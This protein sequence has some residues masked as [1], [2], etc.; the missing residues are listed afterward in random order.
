[1]P[2]QRSPLERTTTTPYLTPKTSNILTDSIFGVK[3]KNVDNAVKR[4][5]LIMDNSPEAQNLNMAE[6]MLVMSE[7]LIKAVESMEEMK[8]MMERILKENK[9]VKE[10]LEMIKIGLKNNGQR[11]E[12]II[13][14]TE[15]QNKEEQSGGEKSKKKGYADVLK[16]MKPALLV[17]G[18]KDGETAKEIMQE[19]KKKVSPKTAKIRGT[20]ET[21]RGNIIIE[22][23]NQEAVK[24][25]KEKVEKR[26]GPKVNVEIVEKRRPKVKV[27]G[28]EGEFTKE[29]IEEYLMEM[30]GDIFTT[31]EQFDIVHIF[32]TSRIKGFKMELEPEVY[33]LVM[34]RKSLMVG[35]FPCRVQECLDV[36][37]CYKCQGFGHK[38]MKCTNET[39]CAKCGGKH[40]YKE[41]KSEIEQCVNCMNVNK[42]ANMNLDVNHIAWSNTCS[43]LRRKETLERR[44]VE[45]RKE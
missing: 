9:Q 5:R 45:Y 21:K 14:D 43:V 11:Q 26:I 36:M 17:K 7:M 19:I 30:N 31:T 25:L 15:R 37:R 6:E 34:Q 33:E 29:E 32:S 39:I 8:V 16:E 12:E 22:C 42:T 2:L 44:R 10:E 35:W 23:E 4:K 27:I 28:M 20:K 41:C 13:K 3:D 38:S 18:V 24:E 40:E 1:M